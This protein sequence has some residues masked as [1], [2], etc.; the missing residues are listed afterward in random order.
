MDDLLEL[1]Q[2]ARQNAHAP[3]SQ[4][5]V[6]AALRTSNGELFSGCNVENASYGA[7]I[8]AEQAAI[9]QAVTH[10]QKHI[11]E[12]LV[13]TQGDTPAPPCGI[14][15]QIISEFAEEDI[16]IHCCSTNGKTKT[17]SLKEIL[18]YSFNKNSLKTEK[19]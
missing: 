13:L 10:G 2:K 6:G 3:Y 5:L 19:L 17:Y 8:C 4:Y 9:C 18:P 11:T 15:R 16:P 14:C 7:T 12:V 1:A